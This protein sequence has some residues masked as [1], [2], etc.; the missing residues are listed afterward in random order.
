MGKDP[1]AAKDDAAIQRAA[2]ER[3]RADIALATRAAE[4][5]VGEERCFAQSGHGGGHRI[6]HDSC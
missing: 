4:R 2:Q 5:Q 6:R 3:R 1:P